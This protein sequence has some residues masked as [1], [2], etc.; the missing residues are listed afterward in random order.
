MPAQCF[1]TL[2]GQRVSNLTCAGFGGVM[3]FSGNK[4]F[5]DKPDATAVANAGRSPRAAIT[6]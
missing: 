5:V 4:Q 1:F 6:S 3:A 2:N